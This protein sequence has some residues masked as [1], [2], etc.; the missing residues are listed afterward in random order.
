MVMALSDILWEP[1]G[2]WRDHAA[3]AGSDTDLFFPIGEDDEAAAP[4]K[5]VCAICPVRE[6]C[7]Q[8][9]L[10]TNQTDG[11]WGGMTGA[12]R[13]RLRRRLRDRERRAS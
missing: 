1:D 2:S 10:A 6:D 5:A 13:R 4:A 9:A 7:L 3:C 8:Y 12:E 11:I